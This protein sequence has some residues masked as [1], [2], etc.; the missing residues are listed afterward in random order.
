MDGGYDKI[1]ADSD[2]MV[3]DAFCHYK[4]PEAKLCICLK[5]NPA[6]DTG[7]VLRQFFATVF[8]KISENLMTQHFIT[9]SELDLLC[10]SHTKDHFC[11]YPPLC[12]NNLNFQKI[13]STIIL[14]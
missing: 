7:G 14:K 6:I 13:N 2:D 4:A 8:E 12:T 9:L 5:G 1:K 11:P 10:I 3:S